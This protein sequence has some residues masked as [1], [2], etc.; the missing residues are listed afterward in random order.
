M[1]PDPPAELLGVSD[2]VAVR[3]LSEA[4]ADALF[5]AIDRSREHLRPWFSFVD[6]VVTRDDAL[7][8]T[9]RVQT[10][11]RDS[12]RFWA[13]I[14]REGRLCGS[15]GLTRLDD[16]NRH[17]EFGIWLAC[18]H[19]GRGTASRAAGVLLDFLFGQYRLHR[20]SAQCAVGNTRSIRLMER[21]GFTR[22]GRLRDAEFAG[23]VPRD[24]FVY[25]LLAQEWSPARRHHPPIQRTVPAE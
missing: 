19:T 11:V 18:D 23:E 8:F 10:N 25:G 15:L 5:G 1:P 2:G 6:V 7:A 20:V 24:V 3:V 4:D 21:L 13:G 16:E 9:R 17:A 14:W 22:E 12:G